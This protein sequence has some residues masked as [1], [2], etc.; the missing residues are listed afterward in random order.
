MFQLVFRPLNASVS[1]FIWFA[2][3]TWLRRPVQGALALHD[4]LTLCNNGFIAYAAFAPRRVRA[5]V[6]GP[7]FCQATRNNP[8]CAHS[9]II[10]G[11]C[12]TVMCLLDVSL[13][14]RDCC[15]TCGR[16]LVS[17]VCAVRCGANRNASAVVDTS[18]CRWRD[19]FV[20]LDAL[21]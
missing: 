8:P 2:A 16:F 15:G 4:C 10:P 11:F 17:C 12:T 5:G 7:T 3:I 19:I 21:R 9:Y 1:M 20:D 13:F 18:V 14:S 6:P